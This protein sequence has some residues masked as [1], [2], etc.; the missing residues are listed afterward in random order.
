MS[1]PQQLT[2]V[3]GG[4]N[5]LRT[6]GAALQDSLYDLVNAY[7]TAKRTIVPRPGTDRFAVLDSTT[8][9]LC[10]FEGGLHVFAD[11]SVAVPSGFTL[12]VLSHPDAGSVAIPLAKI[13]FAKP[14]M[15]FLYVVAGFTGYDGFY[16]HYWLQTGDVWEAS[17]VYKHGDI[18]AP[19]VAN[20]FA[21]Q[22]SRLTAASLQWA[23]GVV[24][25]VSNVIEPT[26][27]N[28][29]YYTVITVQGTNPR[30]GDVEPEWP[31]ETGAQVEET[32]DGL[33]GSGSTTV[34]APPDSAAT[35]NPDTE[36]RY[37]NY[38]NNPTDA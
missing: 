23:P 3:R 5:R 12:H 28:D 29:Y 1:N 38:P 34:T 26:V 15:G 7:V 11:T 19:S 22:A 2:T 31:T 20:G 36:D 6:K 33:G 18:V 9:G 13:Y 37:Q 25:A 30:S 4:I 21:Y 8:K 32:A 17:K 35:P 24:R 14:F 10:S 27:Y 16:Y